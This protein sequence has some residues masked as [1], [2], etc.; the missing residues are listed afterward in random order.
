MRTGSFNG[1]LIKLAV[2]EARRQGAD[3]TL[4]AFRELA[5][6]LYDADFETSSGLPAIAQKLVR[7][8]EDAD[9]LM[10]ATP[11][12]NASIPGPLKNAFDWVSRL[13]PYRFQDKP[14]LLLGASSG[15]G[16]AMHGIE[17]L[18]VTLNFQGAAIHPEVFSVPSGKTAFDDADR[19][20][21]P[22]MNDKL[23]RLIGAF[24]KTVPARTPVS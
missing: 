8:I 15:R 19:F 14:V 9:G 6:P 1:K 7:H 5:P 16:G 4:G 11:E 24:L 10:I 2:E 21:D 20:A 17:A 13:K 3:V 23:V 12:Y 18:R 22:T